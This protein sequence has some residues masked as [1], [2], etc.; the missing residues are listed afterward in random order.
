M[1]SSRSRRNEVSNSMSDRVHESHYSKG[2]SYI[3]GTM[4]LAHL[5][6]NVK[7]NVTQ[8]GLYTVIQPAGY[9][10]DNCSSEKVTTARFTERTKNK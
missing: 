1:R 5:L 3:I 10:N 2:R 6:N 8:P 4:S 7:P 9:N